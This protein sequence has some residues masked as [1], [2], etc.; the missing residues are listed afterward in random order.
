MILSTLGFL[1]YRGLPTQVSKRL[2][3]QGLTTS[4]LGGPLLVVTLSPP[5][6]G[7]K[8]REREGIPTG[9]VLCKRA[10]ASKRRL[11]FASCQEF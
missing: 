6:R 7:R 5:R 11:G 10:K 3:V 2:V 8:E 1:K 9:K 4:R